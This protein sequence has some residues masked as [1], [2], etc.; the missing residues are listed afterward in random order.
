MVPKL[1][2]KLFKIF[3]NNPMVILLSF[4]LF[5][6]SCHCQIYDNFTSVSFEENSHLLYVND[7]HNLNLIVT[8]LKN[9]YTGIPPTLKTTTL[10]NLINSSSIITLNSNYIL[11]S[12]LQDS[13]LTK[14]NINDGSYASLLNYSDFETLEFK[15]EVPINSCSLSIIENTIFIG[16]TKIFLYSGKINKTNIVFR[17]NITNKDSSNGPILDTSINKEKFVFPN[18]NIKS[19]SS[20]QI[21]CE[22]LRLRTNENIYRLVCIEELMIFDESLNNYKY[23]KN[24]KILNEN[25]N[26]FENGENGLTLDSSTINTESKIVKINETYIL[27]IFKK[28]SYYLFLVEDN[29]EILLYRS[30]Y[31]KNN[32][33]SGNEDLFDYNN[34]L[35]FSSEKT[36]FSNKND[37]YCFKI[38][39]GSSNNYFKLYDYRE[40]YIIKIIGYYEKLKDFIILFYQ[41]S[42]NIKYFT[43]FNSQKIFELSTNISKTIKIKSNFEIYYNINE[44]IDVSNIGFLNVIEIRRYENE[45]NIKNETFGIDYNNLIMSDNMIFISETN[46]DWYDYYLSFIEQVENSYTRIYYIKDIIFRLRTCYPIQCESCRKNYSICDDCKYEN[47]SLIKNTNKTCYPIDKLIKGYIYDNET[48]FFEKCYSSCNFCSSS[49]SNSSSHN[50][51]SCLDGYIPS[52]KIPGNCY[53][54]DDTDFIKNSCEKYRINSTGECIEECPTNSPY[55]SYEYNTEIGNYEKINLNLPRY[56]YNKNCYDECPL[57][58]ISDDINNICKCEFAYFIENEEIKCLEDNNCISDYPYQNPDIK[59]CYSSLDNCFSKE[60][61][62]FFNKECYK[63]EC[64]NDKISLSTQTEEIKNYF[65]NI[66]SLNDELINKICICNINNMVWTNINSNNESFYQKCLTECPDGYEPEIVTHHCIE[67]SEISSTDLINITTEQIETDQTNIITEEKCLYK[68]N[69]D[70]ICIENCSP[71]EFFKNLCRINNNS[72]MIIDKMI[73]EINDKI[74]EDSID[75]LLLNITED[76]II[77][78]NNILYIIIKLNNI[79]INKFHNISTLNISDCELKLRNHYNITDNNLIMFRMDIYEK[80][81]L[82]PI[83]QYKVYDIKNSKE[84]NLEYCKD[85]KIVIKIIYKY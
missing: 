24:A 50:C 5:N 66:F 49:L 54:I 41:T 58:L 61:N 71:Y 44:M 78:D 35:F 57:N 27:A 15:L 33:F 23:N 26:G 55:Y 74:L 81:L 17:L 64:P 40:N 85:V 69:L 6:I 79:N 62:Y 29:N 82:I 52:Y 60:N 65:K 1:K 3:S 76:L 9:I 22:P 75:S 32:I 67:K 8:S 42:T 7:Y 21:F 73:K 53:K 70:N 63:N 31:S 30:K 12:C 10:A 77:F 59:E 56:L 37:I 51:L 48:K 11:V 38:D 43:M 68:S 36:S 39:K 80:G 4:F 83:I 13:L 16:Y 18:S 20:K 28:N 84:L 19:D 14:I 2:K 25:I 34:G 45:I 47:Y 46:N 72:P